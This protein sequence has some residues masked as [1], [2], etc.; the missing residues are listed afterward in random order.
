MMIGFLQINLLFVTVFTLFLLNKKI[1][2]LTFNS[3]TITPI[4]QSGKKTEFQ[5]KIK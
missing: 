3:T 1:N 5:K 4:R 2:Q